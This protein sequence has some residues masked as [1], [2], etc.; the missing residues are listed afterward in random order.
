MIEKETVERFLN[1]TILFS[2]S[3]NN[4]RVIFST[5]FLKMVTSDSI[6]ID[7]R[8]QEQV[9]SLDS[10]KSIRELKGGRGS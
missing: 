1:K 10:L 4:D 8:G 6:I 5:G 9:Y 2:W 3:G 7:F